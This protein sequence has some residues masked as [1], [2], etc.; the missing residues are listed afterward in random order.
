MSE[1]IGG[2]NVKATS[3]IYAQLIMEGVYTFDRVV[4][5]FKADTAVVLVVLGA[6]E[7][8]TDA[9]YLAEAKERIVAAE[10]QE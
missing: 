8:V 7:L 2:V 1:V 9:T 5:Y 6:E 3:I 4:K 10:Q